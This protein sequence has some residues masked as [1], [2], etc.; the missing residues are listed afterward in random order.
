VKSFPIWA[1][2]CGAPIASDLLIEMRHQKKLL[3]V[4]SPSRIPTPPK[5]SP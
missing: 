5:R 1:A 4:P 3:L 2:R